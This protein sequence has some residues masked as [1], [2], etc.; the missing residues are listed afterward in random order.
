[1]D[2]VKIDKNKTNV[3]ETLNEVN[4]TLLFDKT[5]KQIENTLEKLGERISPKKD[6]EIDN[7][8]QA[9]ITA[10]NE[11]HIIN[12]KEH[13]IDNTAL[14]MDELHNFNSKIEIKNK[15]TFGFYTYLALSIG[16]IFAIYK[17]LNI[18]KNVITSNYPATE[19][20]I[21]YFYEVIEILAYVIMNFITFIKNL[22]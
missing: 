16:V 11:E 12:N 17:I 21:E 18:S 4:D 20:Y 3:K 15:K 9:D 22:F 7:N 6:L 8:I 1:M 10:N 19:P 13:I 2:D 14:R 5:L